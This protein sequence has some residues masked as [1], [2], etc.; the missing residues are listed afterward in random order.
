M[1]CE[2]MG[3]WPDISRVGRITLDLVRG[4]S[5]AVGHIALLDSRLQQSQTSPGLLLPAVSCAPQCSISR[6][7]YNRIVGWIK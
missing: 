7:L 4:M 3:R 2:T 6:L 1:N 5:V